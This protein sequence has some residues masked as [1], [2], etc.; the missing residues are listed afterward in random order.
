MNNSASPVGTVICSFAGIQLVRFG[1]HRDPRTRYEVI[2]EDHVAGF[3][4]PHFRNPLHA[5]LCFFL[6][7]GNRSYLI[8]P[9][10]PSTLRKEPS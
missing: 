10:F 9:P 8:P 1:A 3:S 4:R 6:D 5:A 2:E 7:H